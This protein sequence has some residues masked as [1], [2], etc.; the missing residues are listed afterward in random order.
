MAHAE[1]GRQRCA[2]MLIVFADMLMDDRFG[3]LAGQLMAMLDGDQTEHHV[4]GRG[5]AGTCEAVAVD[6]EQPRGDLDVGE[7]FGER[8]QVFPVDG[9]TVAVEEARLRQDVATG[10]DRADVGAAARHAAEPGEHRLVVEAVGVNTAADHHRRHVGCLFQAAFHQH[11]NAARGNDR[12]AVRRHK[13][14]AVEFASAEKVRQPQRIHG[15]GEADHGEVRYDDERE[16]LR[17][18]AWRGSKHGFPQSLTPFN[19][20]LWH[21]MG[22]GV[23]KKFARK[24]AGKQTSRYCL[25][26]EKD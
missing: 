11:R 24:R 12:L 6:L 15:R 8:R 5:A 16:A 25:W 23:N 14:P 4:D 2:L 19:R 3:D 7:A 9:A 1:S 22:A 20:E 21:R 26:L 13:M 18:F 17:Q 10:A